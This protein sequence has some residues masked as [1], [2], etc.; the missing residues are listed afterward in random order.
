MLFFDDILFLYLVYLNFDRIILSKMLK[1]SPRKKNPAT[2]M[3][4]S[5]YKYK[6]WDALKNAGVL[7]SRHQNIMI[8]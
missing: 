8:S 5:K 2:S 7:C 3:M 1:N 6:N 4:F